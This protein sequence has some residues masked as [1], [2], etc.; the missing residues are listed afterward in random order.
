MIKETDPLI[1]L[2][3]KVR[4]I[5]R[6]ISKS[7]DVVAKLGTENGPTSLMI[8]DN[9][10]PQEML[11]RMARIAS[12]KSK[13]QQI[14]IQ[15]LSQHRTLMSDNLN[16]QI[17]L[18]RRDAELDHLKVQA[19]YDESMGLDDMNE[20]DPRFQAIYNHARE[21][22]KLK[23]GVNLHRRWKLEKKSITD[24]R[25]GHEDTYYVRLP[26]GKYAITPD[27][28][29]AYMIDQL[30]NTNEG[31]PINHAEAT[32]EMFGY[33]GTK[34]NAR[35]SGLYQ[36]TFMLRGKVRGGT[37]HRAL[38]DTDYEMVKVRDSQR[39]DTG[40]SS[41]NYYL[42]EKAKQLLPSQTTEEQDN[43]NTTEEKSTKRIQE[44]MLRGID[45]VFI[46]QTS[47]AIRDILRV[48]SLHKTGIIAQEERKQAEQLYSQFLMQQPISEVVDAVISVLAREES[49]IQSPVFIELLGILKYRSQTK[50][51]RTNEIA[52][53]LYPQESAEEG[54]LHANGFM[55][56]HRNRLW[57]DNIGINLEADQ[58]TQ[59]SMD[60]QRFAMFQ[61]YGMP[62]TF[63]E[64][65]N[66]Y[67]AFCPTRP[68][69]IKWS[70]QISKDR[71]QRKSVRTKLMWQDP[72]VRSR[73][74]AGTKQYLERIWSDPESRARRLA[75]A[76]SPEA[77]AKRRATRLKRMERAI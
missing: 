75:Q 40:T 39:A 47:A 25:L 29:G 3:G 64:P 46:D 62:G 16:G 30:T 13:Y 72:D 1:R 14:T 49:H 41:V 76:H 20:D 32:L 44:V 60:L 57:Y 65:Q 35:I 73:I 5:D 17:D 23:A 15:A 31:N 63:S 66:Y 43:K 74:I 38:K 2:A 69:A 4:Q 71:R 48:R 27:A 68:V 51:L 10:S 54:I 61:K 36:K 77:N 37:V 58:D 9:L 59:G 24:M 56:A 34:T 50:P 22:T 55:Y 6:A 52:K 7:K 53:A 26:N 28:T 67:L 11:H 45:R 21:T 33:R 18:P 12:I 70:R 42:V 8:S 19:G